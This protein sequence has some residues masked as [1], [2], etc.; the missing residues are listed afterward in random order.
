[1]ARNQRR[2]TT[3]SPKMTKKQ[4]IQI[5]LDPGAFSLGQLRRARARLSESLE[6]GT[7]GGYNEHMYVQVRAGDLDRAIE[8]RQGGEE[9]EERLP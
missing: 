1:M 3:V 7:T 4:A 8:S 6:K 9:D 5:A 2:Y